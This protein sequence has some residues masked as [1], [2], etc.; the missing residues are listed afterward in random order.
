MKKLTRTLALLLICLLL[1]ACGGGGDTADTTAEA[2]KMTEKITEKVTEAVTEEVTEPATD[3]VTE[4]VTESV[5]EIVTTPVTEA[6]VI[7]SP[8]TEPPAPVITT[9]PAM[10]SDASGY[11]V[12]DP[13]NTRGLSEARIGHSFGVASGGQPHSISVNNQTYFDSDPAF[14]ALALDTKSG[15]KVIY[16]TFDCGYEYNNNTAKVLD[17]LREKNVP[18]AF[19]CTMQFLSANT[20]TTWRMINEGHIVGNHSNT[21]PSFPTLTRD[22]M[23]MELYAVDKYMQDYFG[24]STKYFRFPEGAYSVSALELCASLGY[25]SAFWSVA[26]A[27]WDV[28]NQMGYDAAFNTV[29]SRLHPGAV[30]LLH[31]VSNDNVAILADFIDYAR[32][33]GY[34]FVS[35]DAYAWNK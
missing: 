27:D 1:A 35:L 25:R 11:T 21:H 29:V 16:L 20:A 23:A 2:E 9:P 14:N 31:A 13:F 15:G 5:T 33:Q 10:Y 3:A 8:E 34:T 26:Y 30:V 4:P 18:A 19:F 28:N 22:Q 7:Q 6:P 12:Y 32:S 17:I 24:Y